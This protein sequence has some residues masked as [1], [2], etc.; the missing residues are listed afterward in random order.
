MNGRFDYFVIF[1]EMRTGSNFLETNLNDLPGV[2]CHGEAFN[3]VFIGYPNRDELLGVTY[4]ARNRDPF[5]LLDRIIAADGMNGFRFF[6]DHDPRILSRVLEDPRCAKVVLTR[7]PA[8]SYVSRKI[9]GETGQWKL[10]NS[11]HQRSAKVQFDAAEFEAHLET[12]QAFQI[13]LMRAL[14]ITGQTA[15]YIDYDDLHDLEAL[16]GLAAYLGV[17]GR[18]EGLSKALKK[19]NPTEMAEK[20]NNL[21]A[22][23]LALARLD[24]FNL[25]RTPGFEPRR[26]PMVPGYRAG[27]TAPLLFIPIRGGPDARVLNWLAALDGV[28]PDDLTGGFTQKTLRQWK[29]QRPG[30]RSFAVLRHPVWRAYHVYRHDVLGGGIPGLAD[31]L[32]RA[33]DLPLDDGVDREQHRAGFLAFLR[34]VKANL[35]G[36][37]A[38]RTSPAWATQTALLQGTAQFALPDVLL[39]E[40]EMAEGLARLAGDLGLSAPPLSP[41]PTEETS[42]LSEIMGDTVEAAAQDAYARDYMTFGFG[43]WRVGK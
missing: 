19:Q 2:A 13:T 11:K 39:R 28:A 36:Q 43:P 14:Q 3:P 23:E 8:E 17:D 37:T 6:H 25:S 40:E 16:N 35:S 29:R 26:G 33:H 20:V 41:A 42:A 38:L 4:Q 18:L 1:A 7:N 9:A 24:R 27:A 22:M 31:T 32:R 12:L 34:F 5:A 21:R 30:H 10:T 15:F